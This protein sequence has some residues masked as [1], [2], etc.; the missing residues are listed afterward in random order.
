[1]ILI[2][3]VRSYAQPAAAR[4][5]VSIGRASRQA[6]LQPAS[7]VASRGHASDAGSRKLPAG[8][9]PATAPGHAS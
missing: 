5:N 3:T 7:H 9:T 6:W 1:M 4:R 2:A 8:P